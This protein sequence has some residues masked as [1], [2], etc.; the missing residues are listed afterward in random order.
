MLGII[1]IE[2][3]DFGFRKKLGKLGFEQFSTKAFVNNA[4]MSA[5]GAAGRNF[6]F[7]AT[8]M[9]VESISVGMEGHGKIAVGAK[10][11]PAAVFTDGERRRAA[12]IMKD[13]SLMFSLNIIGDVCQ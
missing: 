10:S 1:A 9:T 3:S 2:T 5:A 4:G 12:T 11:L 6:L 8:D 13:E 7:V